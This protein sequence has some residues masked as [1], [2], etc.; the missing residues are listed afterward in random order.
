MLGLPGLYPVG[1]IKHSCK[2]AVYGLLWMGTIPIKPP[3]YLRVLVLHYST[4]SL[5]DN[6]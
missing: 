6:I 4:V 3:G 2:M 5:Q 1:S